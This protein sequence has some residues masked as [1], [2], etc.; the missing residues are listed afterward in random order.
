MNLKSMVLYSLLQVFQQIFF[1]TNNINI[2]S[3]LYSTGKADEIVV[4]SY[5]L[6]WAHDKNRIGGGGVVVKDWNLS[7]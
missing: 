2:F 3:Q 6:K 4:K 7:F 5:E 1:F